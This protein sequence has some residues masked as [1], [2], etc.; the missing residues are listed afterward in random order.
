MVNTNHTSI[1]SYQDVY[2]INYYHQLKQRGEDAESFLRSHA[3]ISRDNGRTPMQ[4]N[5]TANAGFTS[6]TPWLAVHENHTSLNVE[7]QETRPG[8]V[9]NYVRRMIRLRKNN[10]TLIYGA[11]N[12]EDENNGQLF[13]YTREL[14]DQKLLV[15]LNFSDRPAQ[16]ETTIDLSDSQ[17]LI[18][19]YSEPLDKDGYKPYAAVIYQL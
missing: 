5:N 8:S 4:W 3:W 15:V 6:G 11:F 7:E 18:S 2:T 9:L 1:E 16:L 12:P 13:A 10:L 19:N 17:I 14:D